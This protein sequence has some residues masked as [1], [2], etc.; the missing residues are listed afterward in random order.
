MSDLYDSEKDNYS[1]QDLISS[2]IVLDEYGRRN[3][4]TWAPTE[5]EW[6]QS[7]N[8]YGS[9]SVKSGSGEIDLWKSNLQKMIRR[10]NV[11][12]SLKSVVEL[13]NTGGNVLT[14]TINRLTKVIVSED[15]GP[16]TLNLPLL[17][18]D[19][20]LYYN[21]HSFKNEYQLK[22]KILHLTYNLCLSSKSRIVDNMIHSLTINRTDTWDSLF[23]S[24]LTNISLIQTCKNYMDI[25]DKMD[26]C[27][28]LIISMHNIKEN[29]EKGHKYNHLLLKRKKKKIYR[30]WQWIFDNSPDKTINSGNIFLTNKALFQIYE[31][32]SSENLLSII[33]A[34]LNIFIPKLGFNFEPSMIY[35]C[36]YSWN[37]V[38]NWNLNMVVEESL[39]TNTLWPDSVSYDCHTTI[40]NILHS[41]NRK[42]K[43]FFWRFGC[44]LYPV[45]YW[46]Y[47]LGQRYYQKCCVINS[48]DFSTC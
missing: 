12:S 46:N 29:L 30:I 36:P 14:N 1:Y 3:Y 32:G 44:K 9:P 33:H 40:G 25:L 2:G 26:T 10:N 15:I 41:T 4:Y 20:L 27:I 8:W 5:L 18:H 42:E 11:K 13:V 19:L 48:L 43:T 16:S 37:E 34:V 7:R 39:S 24:F 35:E 6:Y 23:S 31:N 28:S 47:T 21:E 45:V 17:C 38:E 22:E